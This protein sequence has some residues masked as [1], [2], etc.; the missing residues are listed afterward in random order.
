MFS[1]MNYNRCSRLNTRLFTPLKRLKQKLSIKTKK[2]LDI[3]YGMKS[4]PQQ[5]V[6]A[7]L[8]IGSW[9]GYTDHE[10]TWLWDK[11][12]LNLLSWWV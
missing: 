11:V 3:H 8:I 1:A 7:N 12:P 6:F 2:F 9:Y 4:C 5:V 10:A